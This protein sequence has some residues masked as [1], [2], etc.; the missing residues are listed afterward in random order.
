[1][2]RQAIP[3]QSFISLILHFY[4]KLHYSLTFLFV[5]SF[6]G[7]SE[8]CMFSTEMNYVILSGKL[9]GIELFPDMHVACDDKWS[10]RMQVGVADAKPWI[11]D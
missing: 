7:G 4:L 10:N 1:M 3:G 11:R 5:I 8:E 2:C 9:H 6:T